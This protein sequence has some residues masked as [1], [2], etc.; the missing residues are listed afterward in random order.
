LLGTVG[1]FFYRHDLPPF[2]HAI[3][4]AIV[5]KPAPYSKRRKKAAVSPSHDPRRESHEDQPD[6]GKIQNI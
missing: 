6:G 5:S 3:V 1:T 2:K 4:S